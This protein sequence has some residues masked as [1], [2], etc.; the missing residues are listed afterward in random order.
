M[1][2][3]NMFYTSLLDLLSKRSSMGK[4]GSSTGV[5]SV[6]LICGPDVDVALAHGVP[7]DGDG[8]SNVLLFPLEEDFVKERVRLKMDFTLA[9]FFSMMSLF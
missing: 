8:T 7:D 3:K 5:G 1:S 4:R 2:V 9:M 6:T